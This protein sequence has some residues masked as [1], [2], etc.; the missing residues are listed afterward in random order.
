MLDSL[1]AEALDANHDLAAA[2]ARV[3]EAAALARIAGA[4]LFPGLAADSRAART[5]QNFVGFPIPGASK[6]VLT[7]YS[8]SYN[9]GL[10]LT[11]EL[12]L[13][14]RL[15]SGR[16]AALADVQAA[17]ANFAGARLSLAARTARAWFGLIEA[18]Q[19]VA[20]AEETVA[21]YEETV[22]QVRDRFERGVRTSLDLR[23]ALAN[24]RTAEAQLQQRRRA[25]DAGT[26]ALEVLLGRYP[27]AALAA[28]D[29]LPS[30][31][32]DVPGGL[33]AD[34]IARRPDLAAA[35]RRLAAGGARVRAAKASLYPRISLTASGGTS[36]NQLKD[37]VDRD[38]SVWNLIG[39]LTA[40]LFQG[41]RL[42]G[43]LAASRA[44]EAQA[45]E[46]F[47]SAALGAYA[48]VE[49]ALAAE[50]TLAAQEAALAE[51]ARQAEAART[52]AEDQYRSGLV[53][54]VTVLETQR[55]ALAARSASLVAH[56]ARLDNRTALH[57][58]LGGGFD[59]RPASVNPSS[60]TREP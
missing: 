54:F 49:S 37:L 4:D 40:P 24:L 47:A 35:E 6:R 23:L 18:R 38:F 10:S 60:P 43:Q 59:A 51:A 9:T 1:V 20:L 32:E 15:R 42:R 48:E 45:L 13:W 34:L 56:R 36:S 57:L 41:G 7:S 50:T 53:D 33:P 25:L 14:G 55:R 11:W 39:N 27:A 58:A 26:R 8:T 44:R 16:S 30:L 19:Q 22:R 28:P 3:D 29:T 21:S 17:Y 52:V 31:P 12:D 46:R 2:A 5:K